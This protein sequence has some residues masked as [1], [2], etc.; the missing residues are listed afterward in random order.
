MEAQ[1][2]SLNVLLL[3]KEA[4]MRS[5]YPLGY[6]KLWEHFRLYSWKTQ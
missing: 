6:Q 5:L 4:I 3:E 2:L 1:I